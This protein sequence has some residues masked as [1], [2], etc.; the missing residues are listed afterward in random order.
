MSDKVRNIE[1]VSEDDVVGVLGGE[2]E[3]QKDCVELSCM[4]ALRWWVRCVRSGLLFVGVGKDDGCGSCP[5]VG[6]V[7]SE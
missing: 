1:I 6:D 5:V 7:W 3:S 4:G 2:L